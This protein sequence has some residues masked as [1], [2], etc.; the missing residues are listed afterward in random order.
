VSVDVDKIVGQLKT[1]AA[2][3]G[4]DRLVGAQSYE[5]LKKLVD[6]AKS[7]IH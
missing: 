3:F 6:D 4:L 5:F 7:G 1:T 2:K